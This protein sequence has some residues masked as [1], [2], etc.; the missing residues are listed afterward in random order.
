MNRIALTF[1]LILLLL[2]SIVAIIILSDFPKNEDESGNLYTFPLSVGET[3]Y[4]LSVRSNYSSTPE[5]SYFS[6][7]K[8]V[9][10]YFRGERENAFCNITIPN[11]LIWGEF[12]VY[13]HG[14][15]MD[16]TDYFLNSNSTHNS[17]YFTFDLPALVKDFEIM[18][19]EGVST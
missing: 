14:Y 16:E 10:V 7:L 11:N 15:L 9:S 5:V 6:S 17:V 19:S 2:F 4:T 1:A 13:N 3:T 18:G 12:S 8:S